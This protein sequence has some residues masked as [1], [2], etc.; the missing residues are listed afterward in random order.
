[1]LL[2]LVW[3]TVNSTGMSALSS[4]SPD[5]LVFIHLPFSFLLSNVNICLPVNWS[6]KINIHQIR[7]TELIM[8][9]VKVFFKANI[10]NQTT[11]LYPGYLKLM[12]WHTK[13][14][15]MKCLSL[16]RTLIVYARISLELLPWNNS[17]QVIRVATLGKAS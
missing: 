13:L 16:N 17:I 11:A 3:H 14:H 7:D 6:S 9:A 5:C 2:W 15:I 1:M 10:Y 8:F 4:Y 12:L